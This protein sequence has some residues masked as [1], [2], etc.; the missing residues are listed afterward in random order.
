MLW[1]ASYLLYMK[2]DPE[3]LLL[4]QQSTLLLVI[5]DASLSRRDDFVLWLIRLIYSQMWYS[6]L[7]HN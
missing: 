2:K 1:D 5:F 6:T 3:W 4:L 7:V